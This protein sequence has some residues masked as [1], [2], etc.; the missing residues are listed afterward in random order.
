M[1][2]IKMKPFHLFGEISRVDDEQRIVEG[3]AFVNETVP[4]ENGV[5]LK[6]SAMEAATAD[7]V[8][9]G[10]SRE[11][12]QPI[13]AGKPLDVTWDDKGAYLRVKV[14]DDQAWNKVKEG[15]YKGFSVGVNPKVMRGKD[16]TA[17]HWFDSSLI[18]IGKDKDA[19][20]TVWRSEGIDPD[21]EVDVEFEESEETEIE[22]SEEIQRSKWT[23]E[24]R[25]AT[26][27]KN[28]G[29]PEERKYPIED[30]DDVD[31]A[32]KL[33]GKAPESKRDAIKK[34]IVSI[35]KRLKL[36][37][38][39]AWTETTKRYMEA[40]ET[41]RGLFA[42][43]ASDQFSY[44]MRYVAFDMLSSALWTLQMAEGYMD[45]SEREADVRQAIDEFAD[46]IVPIVVDGKWPDPD[47]FEDVDDESMDRSRSFTLVRMDG[48]AKSS[49]ATIQRVAELEQS[50]ST[51]TTE[52]D[53]TKTLLTRAQES[54]QT[55]IARVRE[56]ENTPI[57]PR[58][59]TGQ[60]EPV[61][62]TFGAVTPNPD[63]DHIKALKIRKEEITRM[64][65]VDTKAGTAMARELITINRRLTELG[66]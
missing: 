5:R 46:F 32:A 33:I 28:F 62:R 37:V 66:G 40:T 64:K 36:K 51:L 13:A 58:P 7:Y 61:E 15:V 20:F 8:T 16:V 50:I 45:A 65:P 21:A 55:A 47:L 34:R 29:W 11:M 25:D 30:Q 1:P 31:S 63:G 42:D 6:R 23:K 26:P 60:F 17:C 57:R 12:H 24:K 48:F 4:G 22:R 9:N 44:S 54:E 2:I 59:A 39:E 43:L 14:V 35:A 3:Y 52:R 18:D 27:T 41:L 49:M 56:L 53:E 19:K 10:T 38:P